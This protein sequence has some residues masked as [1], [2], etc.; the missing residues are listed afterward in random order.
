MATIE[1]MKFFCRETGRGKIAVYVLEGEINPQFL[2][3]R[4][5]YNTDLEYFACLDDQKY[6]LEMIL[7]LC[8][9][10]AA[11]EALIDEGCITRV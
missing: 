2:N 9:D 6:K 4:S 8:K 1:Q 10:E 5:R 3:L 7:E 11:V